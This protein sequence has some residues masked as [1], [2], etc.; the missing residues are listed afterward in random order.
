[1]RGASPPRRGCEGGQ[2]RASSG[3]GAA[4]TSR[5][6]GGVQMCA[7]ARRGVAPPASGPRR[8]AGK[9]PPSRL[10]GRGGKAAL[11]SRRLS[12]KAPPPPP[13]PSVRQAP[14]VRGGRPSHTTSPLPLHSGPPR[15]DPAA[16]EAAGGRPAGCA[17]PPPRPL[18]PRPAGRS[19]LLR[20]GSALRRGWSWHGGGGGGLSPGLQVSPG[21]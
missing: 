3:S 15:R 7:G 20:G 11:R 21:R 8:K 1:M 19:Q 4:H 17:A 12:L 5:S 14:G 13:A 2:R 16:P 9:R 18:F 10:P 6:C